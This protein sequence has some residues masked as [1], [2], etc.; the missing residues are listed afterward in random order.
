MSLKVAAILLSIYAVAFLFCG[1]VLTVHAQSDLQTTKHRDMVIDLGNGLKTNARLNLPA[2]GDG[3][4]PGVLLV[5]G[6][7]PLDMNETVGVVRI[8]NDTGSIIYPPSR[9]F[10]EIAQYLSERG[11]AVL[12][13][14]KRG[15]G[16]S[17][18][19][20]DSNVW[21]NATVDDLQQDAEKALDVLI[22]QSEVDA[23]HITLVGH[24]E[25][26][27]IVP[28]VAIDNP[29]KV[30]N[31]VL[32]GALAQNLSDIGYIQGVTLPLLYAQQ[33]LDHN[34]NGLLSVKE[35]NSNP[36]FNTIFG[37]LT[38]FLAQNITAANGTTEQL[39][40]QYNTN[41]DTFI[42]IN[43]ELKPRIIY[44]MKSLPSQV[45]TP[46]EKC[47]PR[48]ACPIW[49]TSHY[50]TPTL[51]IISK[52]SSDTS[53]LIQQGKNDSQTPIQQALLLQQ[54]LTDVRHPDHTLITYPDLGHAFYPSSQWL[55]ALGPMEQKV[56]ED[57]FG[58]LS[59]PVRDFKKLTILSS[60][61][62]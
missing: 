11:F 55:T 49:V 15:I 10:F 32:M 31:I 16:E 56:L 27:T 26:T 14:N 6:S 59:D 12:Q 5:H 4:F 50:A 44:F 45:V 8:D 51:D 19:I 40:P 60:Q 54:E 17:Y 13:Y 34:H 33:V 52:V 48:S 7:G 58:W 43:K 57:L 3:P 62:P 1:A 18:T 28:R 39:N 47:D 21:G 2:T 42:S 22:H 24:S 61:M 29:G 53:I 30:N 9:P 46:G 41:N 38:L 36:I 23:N 37:N 20:L 25:G 35:A